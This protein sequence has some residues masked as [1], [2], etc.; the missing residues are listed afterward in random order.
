MRS[1]HL[2]KL[3]FSCFTKIKDNLNQKLREAENFEKEASSLE[4]NAKLQ[5]DEAEKQKLLAEEKLQECIKREEQGFEDLEKLKV[6]RYL[7]YCFTLLIVV[8]LQVGNNN[9]LQKLYF[10]IKDFIDLKSNLFFIPS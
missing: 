5:V 3:L 1:T 10:D 8:I 6:G 9:N 4:E 7:T 2:K